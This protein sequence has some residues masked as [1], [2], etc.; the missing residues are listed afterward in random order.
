MLSNVLSSKSIRALSTVYRY[1]SYSAVLWEPTTA[2][3]FDSV[4]YW[5]FAEN[6]ETVKRS[7]VPAAPQPAFGVVAPRQRRAYKS[8]PRPSTST[9]THG[10]L[11]R[12]RLARASALLGTCRPSFTIT[13]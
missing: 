12:G 13:F 11:R 5:V 4:E 6:G 2:S 3:P 8:H 9:Q 10:V 7:P 1:V